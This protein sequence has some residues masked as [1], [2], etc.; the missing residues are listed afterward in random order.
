MGNIYMWDPCGLALDP[1]PFSKINYFRQSPD[2]IITKATQIA[3]F[4][5]LCKTGTF[6]F[7]Y[8]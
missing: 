2:I 5:I 6:G 8:M 7:N 3:L 4:G 1:G